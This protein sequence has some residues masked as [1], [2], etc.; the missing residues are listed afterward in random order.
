M[1]I[2]IEAQTVEQIADLRRVL[3]SLE[4]RPERIRL[5]SVIRQMRAGVD[6]GI[7][8]R[9]AAELLGISPQAL[10]RWV[11]AGS[12]PVMRKPGSSRELIDRDPFIRLL[13]E[14]R[15]L[16]EAGHQRPVAK[17]IRTLEQRG[18]LVTQ[19]RPN[20]SANELRWEYLHTTPYQRLR[21]AVVL[22]TT[23]HALAAR[24]RARRQETA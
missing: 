3:V 13:V 20:Q 1:P 9:R 8:K 23:A 16:R 11:R 10:E 7:P 19:R 2:S 12:I 18:H 17:A 5:G 24:A 21:N 4:D 6:A 14:V 15:S 22:S